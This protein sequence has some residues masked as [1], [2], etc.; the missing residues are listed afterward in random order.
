MKKTIAMIVLLSS[1][2]AP[3]Q[4]KVVEKD[5]NGGTHVNLPFLHVDTNYDAQGRKYVKV[6]APFVNVENPPGEGNAKVSAPFTKVRESGND[7]TQVRA[8][9]VRVNNPGG[10]HQTQVSA[11]FTKVQEFPDGTT[12]VKA[13]FTKV[14]PR[15]DGTTSVKAPFVK[16]TTQ[17]TKV[18]VQT[19][20][21]R[22][23]VNQ[24][25]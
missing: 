16:T 21:T 19:P 4:A 25:Q 13:P 10:Y 20:A 12:S 11:P 24:S 23:R 3:V 8:P 5:A 14:Q 22:V 15:P 2:L 17:T 1:S 9:F 18:K 7:S 6:R